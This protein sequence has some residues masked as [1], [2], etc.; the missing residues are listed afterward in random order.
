MKT[1]FHDH[2]LSRKEMVYG[3]RYLC[4]QL[5]FLS[6]ILALLSHQLPVSLS[7][8]QINFLYFLINFAAV[9]IIFRRY[10]AQMIQDLPGRLPR[11]LAFSILGLPLYWAVTFLLSKLTLALCPDFFSLNDQ[12]IQ[13]LVSE[14]FLL[15]F[16]GTVLFAPITEEILYRGLLFRG[17][18]DRSPKG[19][20]ILSVAAFAGVHI[21]SYV[22]V[23]PANLLVLSLLQY[24]PAGLIFA[25]CYYHSGSL[26]SPIL[27]HMAVNFAAMMALR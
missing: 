4:F 18:F 12:N 1:S 10:L 3:C 19:A 5:V 2:A 15:M 13:A 24:L 21:F 9:S 14:N 23:A 20:W 11:V 22:G 27:I 8:A 16:L 25:G 17:L 26:L 6:P 7:G